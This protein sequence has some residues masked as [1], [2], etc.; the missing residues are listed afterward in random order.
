MFKHMIRSA[1]LNYRGDSAVAIAGGIVFE[2]GRGKGGG[3][4]TPA[5]RC[6]GGRSTVAAASITAA[7]RTRARVATTVRMCQSAINKTLHEMN[8]CWL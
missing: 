1:Y 8:N 7:T 3:R 5:S 6:R 4:A 2:H